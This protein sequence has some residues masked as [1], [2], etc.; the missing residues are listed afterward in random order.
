M[1]IRFAVT[2]VVRVASYTCPGCLRPLATRLTDRETTVIIPRH[3]RPEMRDL[4][5]AEE[6]R[7]PPYSFCQAADRAFEVPL[8]E[9]VGGRV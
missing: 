4:P 7:R 9:Q 8:T 3:L 5:L 2:H 1:T 6:E